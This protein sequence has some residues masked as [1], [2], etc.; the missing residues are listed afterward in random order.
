MGSTKARGKR[1]DAYSTNSATILRAT[2]STSKQPRAANRTSKAAKGDNSD[3][4]YSREGTPADVAQVMAIPAT[5]AGASCATS[6]K[7]A[8]PRRVA[9]ITPSTKIVVA[10]SMP[11]AARPR[12]PRAHRSEPTT[13][14][15]SHDAA[16]AHTFGLATSDNA[17]S[18][19][20]LAPGIAPNANTFQPVKS[21]EPAHARQNAE[22]T[23]N[24]V[25]AKAC[26]TFR[27]YPASSG[28]TGAKPNAPAR[29][30]VVPT[31]AHA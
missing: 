12:L 6:G 31:F 3:N 19:I 13:A 15:T 27:K 10:A 25:A 21:S 26:F 29:T 20:A 17:A 24:A 28:T 5:N 4:R 9:A 16:M 18:S 23:A 22:T 1:P 7:S 30:A 14:A 8:P 11:Q 2:S